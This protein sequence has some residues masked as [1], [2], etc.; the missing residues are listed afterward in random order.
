MNILLTQLF[1][2]REPRTPIALMD[3]APYARLYGYTTK[4]AYLQDIQDFS[5]YD[6]VGFSTL[7]LRPSILQ[8]L[9]NLREQ[10]KGRIIF[11][12]KATTTLLPE[13][14]E[15]LKQLS[16]EIF[17]G[18]GEQFFHGTNNPNFQDYPP[19][20][21]E[22]FIALDKTQT[23]TEMMSSRGCP[24]HCHFCHNTEKHVSFFSSERTIANA[25]IILE[26]AKRSRVF[27]VDD[28]FTV[29][30]S[31]QLRLLEIADAQ[32]LD[33]RGK[34]SFFVHVNHLR[35]AHLETLKEYQPQEVQLG[36]ESGDNRMLSLM[37]K[38]FLVTKAEE[39]IRL[40][41]DHGIRVACLFILGFPGE[42]KQSLQNTVDFVNRNRQYMSGWWAS[43]YQPVPNTIGW[44][45]AEKRLGRKVTGIWNTEITFV[46]PSITESNLTEARQTLMTY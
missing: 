22:D 17:Y 23:M 29:S 5:P 42:T 32:G 40:L 20:D 37:G 14:I 25:Q 35:A 27:F 33:L 31:R 7:T 8:S 6:V 36:V 24:Y 43:Y 12:G 19:W 26:Q 1:E 44:K 2:K 38:D 13:N 46:D 10:Y 21:R 18:P 30:P 3:L 15:Q 4:V 41:Y 28:I 45:M 9:Q 11:G 16:I 39:K 34:T